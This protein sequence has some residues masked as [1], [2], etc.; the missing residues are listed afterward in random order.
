MSR[1][2]IGITAFITHNHK[3]RYDSVSH[4]YGESVIRGGGIPV[5]LPLCGDVAL[6]AD[7][8][9]KLDGIVFSGGDEDVDPNLY[10]E[11][12]MRQ[13]TSILPERD[14]WEMALYHAA[15]EKG[16]PVLGICR[17]CQI[18]NVA[19]GGSLY[20]DIFSQ[21]AGVLGHAPMQT[22]MRQLYHPIRIAEGSR[23]FEI[24]GT[25]DLPVNSFHHQAVKGLGKGFR[26][27]AWSR[28]GIIEAFECGAGDG[29]V[30]GIQCHPEA[31]TGEHP[32][33]VRLFSAMVDAAG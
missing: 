13:L 25:T 33:F 31:L 15:R 22:E 20:Q 28:E 18:V 23:M 19:E 10:G 3:R 24:F 5:V 2:L 16:I 17:G 7:T 8:V 9:A 21:Y 6:A 27:T 1:P 14:H 32:H 30:L 26:A 29:F 4:Y 11:V 12:P